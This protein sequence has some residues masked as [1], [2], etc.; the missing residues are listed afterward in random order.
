MIQYTFSLYI[1][2]VLGEDKGQ[3]EVSQGQEGQKKET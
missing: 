1:D 3:T 2:A